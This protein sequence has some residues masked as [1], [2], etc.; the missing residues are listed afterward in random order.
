MKLGRVAR[1]VATEINL[2]RRDKGLLPRA[3]SLT[4]RYFVDALEK[5]GFIYCVF[6]KRFI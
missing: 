3:V 5:Q 2:K 1:S 4:H 6:V